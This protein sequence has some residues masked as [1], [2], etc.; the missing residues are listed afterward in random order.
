MVVTINPAK[1]S[2]SVSLTVDQFLQASGAVAT[3]A[4]VTGPS[5]V[6]V[7]AAG[8]ADRSTG[9]AADPNQ[10]FEVGSQ[11]KMMTATVILQLVGEGKIDLDEAAGQYLDASTK[12]GIANIETATV[13]QLLNM[14]SGI[15]N[16]TDVPSTAD[17]SI[18]AFVQAILANP[19][20]IFGAD[21]ALDLVRGL[22]ATA[23]PGAEFNYSNTNYTLLGQ[24]IETA[25]GKSFA[26]NLEERIF[27]PAGMTESRTDEAPIEAGRLRSYA[28]LSDGTILDVTETGWRKGAEGGVI[29]T[30]LDMTKFMQALLVEKTLLAP[31]LLAEMLD[32]PIVTSEGGVTSTFGLGIAT[33]T[34]PGLGTGI[35]FTG[36]TF[37]TNSATYLDQATGRIVSVGVTEPDVDATTLV[38]RLFHD[39]RTAEWR[40]NG[41][42]PSGDGVRFVGVSAASAV[43]DVGADTVLKFGAAAVKLDS[44]VGALTTANVKFADGSVLVVGDNSRG[45]SGDRAGNVIDI[46]HQFARAAG[47]NNQILGLDG[48]DVLSGGRGADRILGGSGNDRIDG[49]D[50]DDLLADGAGNDLVRGGGGRDLLVAHAGN[51]R[52]DG[53]AGSDTVSFAGARTGMLVD[54]STGRATGLGND[55]ILGIEHVVGSIHADRITG[56]ANGNLLRGSDGNDVLR[57]LEGA[58]TLEGGKGR[59]ILAGGA[60]SDLFVFRAVSDSARGAAHDVISDFTVGQDRIALSAIDTDPSASGDQVFS[61]IGSTAFSGEKGELRYALVDRAGAAHDVTLVYADVDGDRV[62][63]LEVQLAGLRLLDAKDFVL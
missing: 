36:G 11:T 59:D 17:P 37:G 8:I 29:S 61:W 58:D 34:L 41:F 49:R 53:G 33:F 25:T 6:V 28:R 39:T 57:G 24:I 54:L 44:V 13:R 26:Q 4:R 2:S 42:D 23:P 50:G 18:P 3:V 30:T 27:K 16:Y 10:S 14:T 47:A 46:E 19:D 51:D 1:L 48:N 35:G 60:G 40:D 15:A 22:N 52:Y 32:N 21:S 9:G 38:A 56:D 55:T 45:T 62:A 5:Q 31:R 43:V 20:A 12:Q 7:D 63:D